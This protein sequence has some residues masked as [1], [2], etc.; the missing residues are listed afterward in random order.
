MTSDTLTLS[1]LQ[2]FGYHGVLPDETARGQEFEVTVNLE[3]SLAAAGRADDLDLTVDYRL[4]HEVVRQVME[5]PPRKLVETLA[6]EIATNLLRG[7][8]VVQA[9]G[10][11]VA[12]PN[13]PVDFAGGGLF[14]RI[15]RTRAAD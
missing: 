13:P 14:V 4:V 9:V 8:P 5:G 10:I 2:F 15:R 11:E 12:K 7:F 1:R 6:E 3:M